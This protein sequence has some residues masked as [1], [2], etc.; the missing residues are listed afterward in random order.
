[1][2]AV[3]VGIRHILTSDKEYLSYLGY[4]QAEPYQTFYVRPPER[5]TFPEVIY[6]LAGDDFDQSFGRDLKVSNIET[7]FMSWSK[8]NVY[9]A[10]IDR[11][12]YLLH[13]ASDSYGF[14]AILSGTSEELFDDDFEVYGRRVLFDIHYGR[15]II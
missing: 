2:N 9:E 6:T 10:I 5:P 14:V 11:I 3:K 13:H 15:G 4:P 7:S 12:I 1:M 8:D